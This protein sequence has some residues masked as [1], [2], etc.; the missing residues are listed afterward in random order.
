MVENQKPKPG[1]R[2]ILTAIPPELM[3]DLPSEDQQAITEILGKP[4][5]LNAYDEDGRAKLEFTDRSG[6]FHFVYVRQ[7]FIKKAL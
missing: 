1:D 5:V 3:N 4:I 2:V 7:D 6:N